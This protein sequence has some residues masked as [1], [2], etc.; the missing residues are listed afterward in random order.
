LAGIDHDGYVMVQRIVC[1]VGHSRSV[2]EVATGPVIPVAARS[3]TWRGRPCAYC[4]ETITTG[5]A[6]NQRYHVKCEPKAMKVA[7][8]RRRAATFA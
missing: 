4:E 5:N 6:G 1:V 2:V 3:R 8:D 7:R